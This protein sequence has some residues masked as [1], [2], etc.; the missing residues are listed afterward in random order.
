M[1]L[2]S[3]FTNHALGQCFQRCP[4]QAEVGEAIQTLAKAYLKAIAKEN[5]E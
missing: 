2:N 5:S 3:R 4:D 1:A